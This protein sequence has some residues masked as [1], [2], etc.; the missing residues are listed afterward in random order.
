[1]KKT[2]LA[3]FILS[4]VAILSPKRSHA[5]M[6][7]AQTVE[8]DVTKIAIVKADQESAWN[9]LSNL[10]KITVSSKGFVKSAEI[11]GSD[12]PCDRV[13]IFADG[14]TRTEEIK[15]IDQNYKF[16]VYGIKKESLPK[17]VESATIAVF[18]K[19]KDGMT[20]V[21]WLARIEGKAE[22]KQALKAQLETEFSQYS[23][24]IINLFSTSIPA[25]K[26]N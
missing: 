15:Q 4:L 8:W 11:K 13:L 14:S 7:T 2:L 25:A 26:V 6:G 9:L 18:T 12:L 23:S 20:E 16:L 10:K 1:M 3:I 19:S 5:Q 21:K 24:G 22:A 17:D